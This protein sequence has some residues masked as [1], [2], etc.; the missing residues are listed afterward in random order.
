MRVSY[1]HIFRDS[2]GTEDSTLD[3]F[4][5]P[6]AWKRF[7]MSLLDFPHA[8][9]DGEFRVSLSDGERQI[10]EDGL[11]VFSQLDCNMSKLVF[12][13][14][15]DGEMTITASVETLL[16]LNTQLVD[17]EYVSYDK[18]TRKLTMLAGTYLIVANVRLNDSTTPAGPFRHFLKIRDSATLGAFNI[19]ETT[20]QANF[21]SLMSMAILTLTT[22]KIV[23]PTYM[24]FASTT[25]GLLAQNGRFEV[26]RL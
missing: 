5:L 24:H 18:D 2:G 22:T 9:Y 13:G 8:F 17:T 1:P 14:T 25:V 11:S 10:L 23:E 6:A 19:N 3:A 21:S 7:A 20:Y 26:I 16:L 15:Q 12:V 4:M